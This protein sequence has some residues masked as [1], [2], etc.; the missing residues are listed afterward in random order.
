MPNIFRRIVTVGWLVL[1][2]ASSSAQNFQVVDYKK[3]ATERA[4]KI[5][6]TLAIKDSAKFFRVRSLIAGEYEA[7]RTIDDQKSES[8]KATKSKNME[9]SAENAEIEKITKK[10]EESRDALNLQF[11]NALKKEINAKQL[12]LVKD[13]LTYNVLPKTYKAYLEMIPSLKKEEKKYIFDALVE[14]REHAMAAG[15]SDAKHGWFG[16]YKGRINN[17][18][19]ARGYDLTKE[20]EGWAERIKAAKK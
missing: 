9:K 14:A 18:L 15:S 2:V 16:K 20:R 13:G 1:L 6:A 17:Y 3:V 12:D 4:Q 7:I 10:S 11:T 19:S 5:V 8:I